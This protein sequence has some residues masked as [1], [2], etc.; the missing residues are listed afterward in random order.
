[1]GKCSPRRRRGRGGGILQVQNRR[2][3]CGRR[4]GRPKVV[5]GRARR[6]KSFPSGGTARRH[7]SHRKSA[8]RETRVRPQ[9]SS[10]KLPR[11]ENR[12]V[13]HRDTTKSTS[14]ERRESS[15]ATDISEVRRSRRRL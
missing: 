9:L 4:E 3:R 12:R 2:R 1:M 7:P 10:G 13:F 11:P 8:K 5:W 14:Q 6:R 15:Q